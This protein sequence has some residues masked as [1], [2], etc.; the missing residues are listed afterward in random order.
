MPAVALD[1]VD[2]V[3]DHL[4]ADVGA[5]GGVVLEDGADGLGL[6]QA[7]GQEQVE[8]F[9]QQGLVQAALFLCAPF[10][11]QNGKWS[12]FLKLTPTLL[13]QMP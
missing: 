12:P 4:L 13:C 5:Q 9:V 8:V 3:L 11:V 7:G 6:Q 2:K 1:A 10:L